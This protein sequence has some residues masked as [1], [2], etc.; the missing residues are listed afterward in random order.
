MRSWRLVLSPLFDIGWLA[1]LGLVGANGYAFW[2]MYGGYNVI[3]HLALRIVLYRAGVIPLKFAHFLDY[4][5]ALTLM[6]KVGGGYI[7]VHRYLLEYFA[8]QADG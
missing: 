6:Y 2:F 3:Q 7:F 4:T 1:F 5:N 8:S